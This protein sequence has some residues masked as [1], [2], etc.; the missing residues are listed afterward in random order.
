MDPNNNQNVNQNPATPE[1]GSAMPNPVAA[2]AAGGMT[3]QPV[4]PIINPTGGGF[5]PAEG[6][7]L[8][9]PIMQP[10]PAP[11]PDPVE[12][13]LKAPMVAAGPVPG[14]IGSAVSGAP[15]GGAAN[16][17]PASAEAAG[18]TNPMTTPAGNPF[19]NNKQT[20]SVAFN[21]PA[22]QPDP[23]TSMPAGA[24]PAPAKAKSNKTTLI[25]LIAVAAVIV[26]VLVVILIMQLVGGNDSSST[27]ST[28]DTPA[29][30]DDEDEGEDEE[31]EDESEVVLGASMCTRS[32]NETELANYANATS[33][34]I[35]VSADFDDDD[36]LTS[37]SLT[38]SVIYDGEPVEEKNIQATAE[39]LN[40][41]EAAKYF[42]PVDKEGGVDLSRGGVM[43]NWAGLEFV[44][45]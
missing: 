29:V 21:D 8:T 35:N 42:L 41:D 14:S 27:A 34:T 25:V 37:V 36:N 45:E 1:A 11:A 13:E 4:N 17:M 16:N 19:E 30:I 3:T 23:T 20:P 40:A 43:A 5:T 31:N 26:V 2:T 44:C 15:A 39:A 7:A 28:A 33:G 38:E 32:M 18:G 10:E 9:D 22:T 6:L 12:E 24:A